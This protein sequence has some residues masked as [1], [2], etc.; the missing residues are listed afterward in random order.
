[1]TPLARRRAGRRRTSDV[2]A[3]TSKAREGT[4]PRGT[5]CG[6]RERPCRT[7]GQAVKNSSDGD[8]IE[9]GP[10]TY[11]GTV[12][13]N[14]AVEIYSTAGAALTLIRDPDPIQ[15]V[16]VTIRVSGVTFGRLNG[17]F[18]IVGTKENLGGGSGGAGIEGGGNDVFDTTIVGNILE[19]HTFGISIGGAAR[20]RL[21]GNV[22]LDNVR[23]FLVYAT[24]TTF[25]GNAA[26]GNEVGIEAG[27]EYANE[28]SG[29]TII[30][31]SQTG[32]HF[33]IPAQTAARLVIHNNNIYGNG[34]AADGCGVINESGGVINATNNY[35]GKADGPGP[36][37]G[38]RAYGACLAR[39]NI[40]TTPFA[41]TSFPAVPANA[42]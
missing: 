2:S 4:K 41:T 42:Q 36:N 10:G 37:P 11:S 14:K 30:G 38:D 15:L 26:I 39:G 17:G 21:E 6:S 35:W 27:S 3:E 18:T 40:V 25:T 32:F 1:M 34:D 16:L 9:V 20:V 24:G 7:I 19:G 33:R 8:L 28:L 31:N 29:N 5:G 12:I 22:A 23:G 13:I